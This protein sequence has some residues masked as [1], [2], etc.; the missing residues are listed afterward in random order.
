MALAATAA[1]YFT[2]GE[3]GGFAGPSLVG[4]FV[5]VTGSFTLGVAS[6]SVVTFGAA[7][8]AWRMPVPAEQESPP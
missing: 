6:L 7:L 4:A 8:A 3:V 2:V 1:L 5:S